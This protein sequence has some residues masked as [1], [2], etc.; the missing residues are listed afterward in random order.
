MTFVLDACAMIAFL[1]NEAGSSIVERFLPDPS[2][3]CCAHSLNYCEVY[4]DLARRFDEA[5]A[6]QAVDDLEALG[7]APRSDLSRPF[8]ERMGRLKAGAR[9]SLADCACVALAQE[10]GGTVVTADRKEFEPLVPL[11]I[12]PILFNR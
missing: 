8:W 1:M 12:C 3:R 7:I 9:L 10:V 6:V 5:R 2:A 11:A 4:Y